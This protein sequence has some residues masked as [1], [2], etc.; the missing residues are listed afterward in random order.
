[1]PAGKMVVFAFGRKRKPADTTEGAK[2]VKRVVSARKDLV[3]IRLMPHVENDLIF[4]YVKN[5]QKRNDEFHRAE[6]RADVPA[7]LNGNFDDPL[8]NFFGER[9]KRV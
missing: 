8:T 9:F 1:M 5:V 3:R 7:V 2:A 4:L 6:R